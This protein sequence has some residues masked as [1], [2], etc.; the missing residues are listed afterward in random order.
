MPFAQLDPVPDLISLTVR[1]DALANPDLAAY[2]WGLAWGAKNSAVVELLNLGLAAQL[3]GAPPAV[4]RSATAPP[5]PKTRRKAAARPRQ[6]RSLQP[7]PLLRTGAPETFVVD[8]KLPAPLRE[9][10]VPPAAHAVPARPSAPP[11]ATTTAVTAVP[12]PAEP[13]NPEPGD[14]G[15]SPFL[16]QFL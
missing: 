9:I 7:P 4:V 12:P 8:E 5:A 1:I 10:Q 11:G 14:T 16:S 3:G 6:V 15:M 2:V 13:A